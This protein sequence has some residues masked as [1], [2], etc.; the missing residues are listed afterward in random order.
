MRSTETIKLDFC[1]TIFCVNFYLYSSLKKLHAVTLCYFKVQSE[2]KAKIVLSHNY[3]DNF[4][5]IDTMY[6]G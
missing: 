1:V 5:N 4:N 6:I 2:A 3:I